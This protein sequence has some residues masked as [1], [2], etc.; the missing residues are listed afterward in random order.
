MKLSEIPDN[1]KRLILATCD[2]DWNLDELD[3]LDTEEL[4][5]VRY[6]AVA[7]PGP[8]ARIELAGRPGIGRYEVDYPNPWGDM[9][10]ELDEPL[11][12]LTRDPR[13]AA[14][15]AADCHG[16]HEVHERDGYAR[17]LPH[18]RRVAARPL[19]RRVHT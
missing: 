12:A 1:V 17:G 15:G 9:A 3:A 13:L 2:A 16:W 6:Y 7:A 5:F 14:V 10:V 18:A 19:R 11:P 8:L 4:R